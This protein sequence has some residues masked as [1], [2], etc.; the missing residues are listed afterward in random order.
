MSFQ[1]QQSTGILTHDGEE[2]AAGYSGHED[3]VNN[4][5]AQDQHG[6]GPIP[7]GVYTIEP[8][9]A[10]AQVGPVAMNLIPSPTNEMFGRGDFLIHGDTAAM[11][12]TAS[13]GCII[14]PH[15]VRIE[16]GTAVVAGDNQLTVVVGQTQAEQ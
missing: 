12:H 13:H 6:I 3:G 15:N 5:A 10:D 11:D 14:M 8:P 16:V 4:P 9:H 1:Y 2:L 7:Q